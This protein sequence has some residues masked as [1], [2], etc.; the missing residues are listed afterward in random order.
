MAQINTTQSRNDESHLAQIVNAIGSWKEAPR[1]RI[2]GIAN[3]GATCYLNTL[4]QTLLHTP[5]LTSRLFLMAKKTE[6]TQLKRILQEL[7]A[8]FSNLLQGDGIP[9]SAKFLTDSFGWSSDEV[10][11]HQDIQE[12]NRLLFEQLENNLKDT[13]ETTLISDLYKGVFR[14][15]IKCLTCGQVSERNDEFQDVNLSVSHCDSIEDALN[16]HTQT[17]MLVGENQYFCENCKSRVN[18]TKTSKFTDLPPILTLS[19]SRFYFNPKTMEACKL[20]KMCSFPILLDM[21]TYLA[22]KQAVPVTYDLF[23]IVIHAGAAACGGHYH[24][25]IK[26]PYGYIGDEVDDHTTQKFHP[27]DLKGGQNLEVEQVQT[28][29]NH[30]FACHQNATTPV[31]NPATLR[32]RVQSQQRP[33][34]AFCRH[35]ERRNISP[36]LSLAIDARPPPVRKSPRPFQQAAFLNRLTGPSAN[37]RFQMPPGVETSPAPFVSRD[38]I[39]RARSRRKTRVVSTSLTSAVNPSSASV[40]GQFSGKVGSETLS[41]KKKSMTY[42]RLVD[43]MKASLASTQRSSGSAT[44]PYSQQNDSINYPKRKTNRPIFERP[45]GNALSNQLRKMSVQLLKSP[46]GSTINIDVSEK[47]DQTSSLSMK[48]K[49]ITT[50]G[51]N[52]DNS[53]SKQQSTGSLTK[54]QS[55]CSSC[56]PSC[57]TEAWRSRLFRQ[58]PKRSKS[59]AS[60]IVKTGNLSKASVGVSPTKTSTPVLEN[61]KSVTPTPAQQIKDSFLLHRYHKSANLASASQKSELSGEESQENLQTPCEALRLTRDGENPVVY[62]K[63]FDFNDDVV[64]E[65]SCENFKYVFKGPECAYMLFYRRIGQPIT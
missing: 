60:E 2:S 42:N 56:T 9:V 62:G 17:E 61:D 31:S 11:I 38:S 49:I 22:S 65:V 64:R 43:N 6:V 10:L 44:T 46:S 20:D 34:E 50:S 40:R 14:T 55:Q 29:T 16:Y 4:L 48:K 5:D 24:A 3:Q 21:T 57:N 18:A 23:S 32:T 36:H 51:N 28:N 7:L 41:T 25:Y 12:L 63:W 58:T 54:S 47:S 15:T 52:D 35:T 39:D 27:S 59:S 33:F 37:L 13:S 30:F 19:L 53:A 1:K 45:I 8:L 26:D